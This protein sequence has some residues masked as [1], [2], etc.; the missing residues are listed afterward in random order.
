VALL[1]G[2]VNGEASVTWAHC[3]IESR[4]VIV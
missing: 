3:G 4:S 1:A 2:G